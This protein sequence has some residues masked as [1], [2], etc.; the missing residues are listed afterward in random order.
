MSLCRRQ[1]CNLLSGCNC[2]GTIYHIHS[3]I[4]HTALMTK[5]LITSTAERTPFHRCFLTVQYLPYTYF[6]NYG[7]LTSK[8]ASIFRLTDL[9]SHVGNASNRRGYGGAGV[10]IL[11]S[12]GS[13]KP[14]RAFAGAPASSGLLFG[15]QRLY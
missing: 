3:L 10:V 6:R 15:L 8:T 9:P 5:P 12:Q 13:E 1:P 14:P 2:R 4:I 7:N 11:A